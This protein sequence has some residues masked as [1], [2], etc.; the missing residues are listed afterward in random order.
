MEPTELRLRVFFSE[1]DNGFITQVLENKEF[2]GLS[3]WGPTLEDS[4][5]EFITAYLNWQTVK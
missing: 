1:E 2:S 5:D 3:A 4:L